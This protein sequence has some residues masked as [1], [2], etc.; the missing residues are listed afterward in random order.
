MT[1]PHRDKTVLCRGEV[2]TQTVTM[3]AEHPEGPGEIETA[4][5]CDRELSYQEHGRFESPPR[6][7]RR[8]RYEQAALVFV[9]PTCGHETAVCPICSDPNDR[10]AGGYI[11]S[12]HGAEPIPCHNCNQREI[13]E[14]RKRWGHTGPGPASRP[15]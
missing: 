9:C 10:S 7:D 12:S 2:G 8:D 4:K 14:R 5:R 13:A 1:D 6:G 3:P 15:R 11:D